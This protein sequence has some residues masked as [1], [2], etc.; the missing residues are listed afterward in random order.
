MH[1]G[2]PESPISIRY[3]QSYKVS[4]LSSISYSF[5]ANAVVRQ[6]FTMPLG[7]TTE[8]E[9]SRP[10]NPNESKG[11]RSHLSSLAFDSTSDIL[12][13]RILPGKYSSSS[14]K[15]NWIS[16]NLFSTER[17]F[18][19]QQPTNDQSSPLVLLPILGQSNTP[20]SPSK[21]MVE[22]QITDF[23]MRCHV[24]SGH[25]IS[26]EELEELRQRAPSAFDIRLSDRIRANSRSSPTA[27]QSNSKELISA[28]E[29]EFGMGLAAGGLDISASSPR[30][31]L[32]TSS[33]NAI[34]SSY[35]NIPVNY[36]KSII[37]CKSRSS[38]V[39]STSSSLSIYSSD[40]LDSGIY[41]APQDRVKRQ[42][43]YI[44]NICSTSCAD[45]SQLLQHGRRV[46]G[47]EN[48]CDFCFHPAFEGVYVSSSWVGSCCLDLSVANDF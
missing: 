30:V 38:T 23:A 15:S 37:S 36:A 17:K 25:G 34:V 3:F 7:Q 29:T 10:D 40:S 18:K 5:L 39:E 41:M 22:S 11:T 44:C 8:V 45:A 12:Q 26:V 14:R 43:K 27:H 13:N 21:E 33:I 1:L 46:H 20:R 48:F 28:P 6:R 47:A 31:P 35:S 24:P 16:Q 2:V 32:E 4:S 42:R 9:H 19:P